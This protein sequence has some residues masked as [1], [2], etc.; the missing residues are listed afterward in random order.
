MNVTRNTYK[1]LS[2]SFLFFI[3]AFAV[4]GQNQD[5]KIGVGVSGLH[6]IAD[7]KKNRKTKATEI[8]AFVKTIASKPSVNESD[9]LTLTYRLYTNIETNRIIDVNFPAVRDFYTSNITPSRQAFREEKLDGITYKVIDIRVLILQ[10]REMGL[11]EIPEGS[12]TVE[13]AIPTGQRVRNQWGQVYE[14]VIRER[15]TLP[16]ESVKIRVLNL[17]A[18]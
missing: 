9:T 16:I 4:N 6:N 5:G 12:I 8:K 1:S 3:F 10:P 15:K 2:L 18:I 17:T 11:K 13:Y 7:K 14:E